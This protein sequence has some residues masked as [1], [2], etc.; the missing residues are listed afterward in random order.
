M[1]REEIKHIAKTKELKEFRKFG[2]TIGIFLLIIGSIF[3]LKSIESYNYLLTIGGC[4][5][6]FGLLIPII[7]RPIFIIWMSFAAVMG[8]VM[9]RV[10]LSLIF[11]LIFS[12]VSITLKIIGKELLQ[13]KIDP[14]LKSY[15]I[16]RDK[17]VYDP[18][19]SEKQY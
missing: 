8:F 2:I 3:W 16:I 1:F 11:Y 9:T 4:I 14:G 6:G 10:I 18:A 17:K 13:E 19:N 7:L 15:W 12:P 5:L